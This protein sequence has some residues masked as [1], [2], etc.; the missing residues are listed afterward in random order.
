MYFF[1][2]NNEEKEVVEKQE[3]KQ[4][5]LHIGYRTFITYKD[6]II[7]RCNCLMDCLEDFLIQVIR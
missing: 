4:S 6:K 5:K 3:L 7:L 2:R 1:I